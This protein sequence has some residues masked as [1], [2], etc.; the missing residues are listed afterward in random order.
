MLLT[1]SNIESPH[2]LKRRPELDPP[3]QSNTLL[4]QAA[5]EKQVGTR[6]KNP[7]A[8]L[9]KRFTDATV[10]VSQRNF[11]LHALACLDR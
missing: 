9:I 7:P 1:L 6:N 10:F 11:G 3:P 5:S 2:N 8:K 4:F